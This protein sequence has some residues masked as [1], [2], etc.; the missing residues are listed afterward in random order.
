MCD[1][2][3]QKCIGLDP[4]IVKVLCFFVEKRIDMFCLA[5]PNFSTVVSFAKHFR[6]KGL[7]TK[8]Q[9]IKQKLTFWNDYCWRSK[10][11]CHRN[12]GD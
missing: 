10:N 7:S 3:L 8:N 12:K 9:H 11:Y 5:T 2:K 4:N 1:V 6:T